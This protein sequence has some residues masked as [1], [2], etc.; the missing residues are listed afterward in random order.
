MPGCHVLGLFDW[1]GTQQK[2]LREKVGEKI[3]NP[4][5]SLRGKE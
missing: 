4:W 5:R 2:H 1:R 3:I